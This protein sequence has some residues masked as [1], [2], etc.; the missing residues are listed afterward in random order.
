MS[1]E[2]NEICHKKAHF[3]SDILQDLINHGDKSTAGSV[4]E[5]EETP[6]PKLLNKEQSFKLKNIVMKNIIIRRDQRSKEI[7][8]R[9]SQVDPKEAIK[10]NI[11]GPM[12]KIKNS[13][14]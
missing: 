4:I 11:Q 10:I 13:S 7:I 5:K 1:S 3:K 12:F 2:G 14:I 8:K 9:N 6:L